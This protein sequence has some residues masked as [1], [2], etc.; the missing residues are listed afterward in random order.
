MAGIRSMF[1]LERTRP[2]PPRKAEENFNL[3][4]SSIGRAAQCAGGKRFSGCG[5]RNSCG[6]G[7]GSSRA[8]DNTDVDN[9]LKRRSRSY[10]D[11]EIN[12]CRS[13]GYRPHRRRD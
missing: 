9:R 6:I 3:T 11:E 13:G 4:S 2:Q 8:C 1:R 10:A 7:A 5:R 12:L